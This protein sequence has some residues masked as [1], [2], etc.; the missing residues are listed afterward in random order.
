M[1][2]IYAVVSRAISQP[3]RGACAVAAKFTISSLSELATSGG[4]F[5]CIFT[6]IKWE[7][8]REDKKHLCWCKEGG[9]AII[10]VKAVFMAK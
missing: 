2:W 7:M 5:V 4:F 9:W 3:H 10:N 8:R 6:A 1:K